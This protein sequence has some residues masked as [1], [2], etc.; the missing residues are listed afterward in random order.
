VGGCGGCAHLPGQCPSCFSFSSLPTPLPSLPTPNPSYSPPVGCINFIHGRL[1]ACSGR[2][3]HF[4]LSHL[5]EF[6][7]LII[8]YRNFYFLRSILY[9]SHK[10]MKIII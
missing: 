6:Q 5:V 4:D 1:R 3:R 10:I 2:E 7:T 9:R 8:F